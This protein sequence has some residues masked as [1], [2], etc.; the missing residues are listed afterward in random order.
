ME[1]EVEVDETDVIGVALGQQSNIRV[2]A[3][4]EIVFKGKVTEIGSSALQQTTGGVSTQESRDFK[5]VITLDNPSER[6]KPGLSASAD[7]I[8]AEKKQALAVPI[9]SLVLRDKPGADPNVPAKD[10][11]GI[12]I[13]ENSR[14][15]FVV[16]NKGI[17]GGMM[18]EI[19][20]GLA[21]GQEIVTGPYASLRELKDGVLVK[22]EEKKDS[23]TP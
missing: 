12:Y 9:S 22:T 15:K 13:V 21:E 14:V 3:Y 11:E 10:E 19:T 8:V 20:S 23:K 18:I 2:D 16:V 7:I 5:V 4:P 1:V 6:L 17:T